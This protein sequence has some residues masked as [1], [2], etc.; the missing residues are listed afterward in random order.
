[1]YKLLHG[2]LDSFH[3]SSNGIIG[4]A[5]EA[6]L[7]CVVVWFFPSYFSESLPLLYAHSVHVL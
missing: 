2:K 6:F 7:L 3:P 5:F 1:M 4:F